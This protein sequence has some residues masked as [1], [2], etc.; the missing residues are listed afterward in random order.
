MRAAVMAERS[1]QSDPTLMRLIFE[2]NK[3]ASKKR[4]CGGIERHQV[5]NGHVFVT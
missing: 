1:Q 2:I 3:R 4:S 5:S